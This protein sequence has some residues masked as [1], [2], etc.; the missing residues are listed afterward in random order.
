MARSAPPDGLDVEAGRLRKR[1]TTTAPLEGGEPVPIKSRDVV[2]KDSCK[3]LRVDVCAREHNGSGE[4][5]QTGSF[6]KERGKAGGPGPFHHVVRV[7]EQGAHGFLHLVI[8][9][10]DNAVD[11]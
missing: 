11:A 4:T 5:A 1:R 7:A 6:L 10:L 9:D 8:G 2:S 3:R